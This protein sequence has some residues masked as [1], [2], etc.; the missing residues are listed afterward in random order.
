V[1]IL[2]CR[3]N[4]SPRL[5][6][7]AVSDAGS[8]WILVLVSSPVGIDV[9]IVL[10]NI[11]LVI[12]LKDPV[13]TWLVSLRGKKDDIMARS[14]AVRAIVAVTSLPNDLVPKMLRA[15]NCVHEE[16]EVVAG[17]GIAVEV[18][19][20]GFFEDAAEFDEARGHHGEVGEHVGAAEEGVEGAHGF[21]DAAAGFDDFF[22]GAGGFLVPLPGVLERRYL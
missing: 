8:R 4:A 7:Y 15:K 5:A 22:V 17:S 16:L 12:D 6:C 14:V 11:A 2:G 21:G 9:P 1:T 20:A 19:G 18:D 10:L 3:I 13:P